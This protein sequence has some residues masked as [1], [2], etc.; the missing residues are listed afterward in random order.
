MITFTMMSLSLFFKQTQSSPYIVFDKHI[1]GGLEGK[2]GTPVDVFYTIA[3]LGESEATT[4]SIVDHGIPRDMFS[5][6]DSAA[7]LTWKSLPAGQNITHS[8]KVT[9]LVSGNLRMN[10][11]QLIYFDGAEKLKASSTSTFWFECTNARSIGAHTNMKG[12][13]MTIGASVALIAIPFLLWFA[14]RSTEQQKVKT[15]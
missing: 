15:N 8:F 2:V 14:S 13:A 6:D 11:S 5:V 7:P 10:P 4:L 9:P 12:Y 1:H 3:N